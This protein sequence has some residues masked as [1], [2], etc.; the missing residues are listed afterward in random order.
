MTEREDP[1]IRHERIRGDGVELHVAVAGA[2]PPVVLLHGF[3]ENWTS[4]RHQLTPLVA[5]GFSVWVPDMRG[6][7]ES[8]RP[9]ERDAYHLRH[10]V[11][12]VAAVVRA[13]GSP[14]AHI[15]GHDWGGV[16][17]W[18]FAAR[19]PELVDKL[20]ILN[21]PHLDIY[22]DKVRR[23]PQMFR[24][25]YVLLFLIPPVSEWALSAGGYRAVRE[26]FCRSPARRGAFDEAHVRQYIA[27]LSTPGALTA[28]LNYY[29]A[30]ARPDRLAWARKAPVA[31][32]TLVIW[33]D[34]DPALGPEVLDNLQGVAPRSRVHHIAD[35]GHWV[36]NEAPGEV[37]QL[38]TDFLRSPSLQPGAADDSRERPA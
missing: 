27:A 16:V 11:A 2:G 4:W 29:R 10:L 9:R 24:S 19:H 8:E 32:E 5:A 20:V 38:L 25:W 1:V 23:P 18:T 17:A 37:N 33:G 31:A 3:P 13:T 14:R 21:A 22:L 12:D 28:A 35:A 26:M 34:R 7:N 36:Q 15:V 30:N 6:Y